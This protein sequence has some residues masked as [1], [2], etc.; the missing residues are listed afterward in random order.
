MLNNSVIISS[1]DYSDYNPIKT[2]ILSSTID[3]ENLEKSK[4]NIQW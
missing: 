4:K 1:P 3:P 2:I